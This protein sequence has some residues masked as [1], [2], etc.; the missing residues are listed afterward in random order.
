MYIYQKEFEAI[1]EIDE[2]AHMAK[3]TVFGRQNS[4]DKSSLLKAWKTKKIKFL[5]VGVCKGELGEPKVYFLSQ[6]WDF[7]PTS[8]TTTPPPPRR[9]GHTHKKK[10]FDVYFVF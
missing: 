9:L 2:K 4:I 6:T 7:V 10:L 1:K 8:L 5:G 3:L